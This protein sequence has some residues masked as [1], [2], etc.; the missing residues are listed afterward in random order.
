MITN[1]DVHDLPEED[2]EIVQK[3]A[4]LIRQR[5]KKEGKQARP[6]VEDEIFTVASWPIG[7]KE[8]LTRKDIYD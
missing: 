8:N 4:E 1:V 7:A 5:V 2:A 3:I 6:Q